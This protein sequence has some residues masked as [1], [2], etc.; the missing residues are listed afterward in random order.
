ME[1]NMNAFT[2]LAEPTRRQIL[3]ALRNGAMPVNGLVELVGMSQPVVSK[4]LRILREAGFVTVQPDG[5]RRFY[6]LNPA[7]LVE[8]DAWIE[9]YRKFWST[10]LE[11]LENH[12]DETQ[13][14]NHS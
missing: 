13:R 1:S 10:R 12:L 6:A 8:V 3:D 5:Q 11:A 2:A 9:P 4:H 14:G 7:P